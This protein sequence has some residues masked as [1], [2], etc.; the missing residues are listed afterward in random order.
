[1]TESTSEYKKRIE[2]I[3]Q[4]IENEPYMAKMRE[5]I[6]EGISKT[7]IR[8][9]TVEEQFQSVL[10]ETTGKDVIS[11]PEIILA[12][13]G[14]SNLKTRLDEDHAQVTA[15][16]A[17]K[18]EKR[19][20]NT[21]SDAQKSV[22]GFTHNNIN[23]V[24]EESRLTSPLTIPP[25]T[26]VMTGGIGAKTY[27]P[28]VVTYNNELWCAIRVA[29]DHGGS[30]DGNIVLRKSTDG[31]S[32]TYVTIF[33]TNKDLRDP[34][35]IVAPN[36][37]LILRYF[38]STSQW[39]TTR[40]KIRIYNG[41]TWSDEIEMPRLTGVNG[42]ARGNMTIKDGVIYS[43]NYSENGVG[44]IVKSSDNGNSWVLGEEI[45]PDWKLNE[46]SLCYNPKD[47]KIYFVGRQQIYK[48]GV[49]PH[50]DY[51][52]YMAIGDSDDGNK[53]NN[54]REL[55]LYGHAPALKLLNENKMIL[56]YKNT[57]DASLDMV[58]LA[59]GD[60]ASQNIRIEKSSHYDAYYSDV[61]ILNGTIH[62]IYHDLA[63][64]NIR[65]YRL[66][67]SEVNQLSQLSHE[68]IPN[69]INENSG[70]LEVGKPFNI[71]WQDYRLSNEVLAVGGIKNIRL[72]LHKPFNVRPYGLAT[73]LFTP[74]GNTPVLDN[75]LVSSYMLNIEDISVSLYNAGTTNINLNTGYVLKISAF[76][77]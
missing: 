27:F 45:S 48:E 31:I 24:N 77:S 43:A 26:L 49:L 62:L 20:V 69:F 29:S 11:A 17:Y 22:D 76:G 73:Y 64:T 5:D 37:N 1:M 65:V 50:T 33:D 42:A 34:A 13:N 51:Q 36:G 71:V 3:K 58:I 57:V 7:G 4:S 23:S 32:W 15:Q 18:A 21:L 56:T 19:Q 47:K 30:F 44:Y 41:A 9:A 46:V 8:Q 38:D 60:I 54:I 39:G 63:T 16:L 6:A 53:W 12:R 2:G 66:L 25:S 61:A 72:K 28:T 68:H 74:N 75:I 35:L 40:V 10:D 52:N 14:K 70:F 59:N 67:V 55:P